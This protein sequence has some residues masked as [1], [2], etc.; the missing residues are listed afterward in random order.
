MVEADPKTDRHI[1]FGAI[2]F[3]PCRRILINYPQVNLN[4]KAGLSQSMKANKPRSVFKRQILQDVPIKKY[5]DL[6]EILSW[7]L[8]SCI[9]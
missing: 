1:I 8:L 7:L 2:I 6:P 9:C 4:F 5:G 3:T